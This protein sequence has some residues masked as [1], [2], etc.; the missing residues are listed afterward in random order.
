MPR[1]DLAALQRR[2]AQQQ[3]KD[4]TPVPAEPPS[5]ST[6]TVLASKKPARQAAVPIPTRPPRQPTPP[7]PPPAA[8][9]E[10]A[11]RAE[12]ADVQSERPPDARVQT[13]RPAFP[14]HAP[15]DEA[16]RE[17]NRRMEEAWHRA[18]EA[19]HRAR[20]QSREAQELRRARSDALLLELRARWPALFTMPVPLAIGIDGEIR[21][22]L[23]QEAAAAGTAAPS[24]SVLKGTMAWWTTERLPRGTCN[25]DAPRRPG[26]AAGRRDH[27]PRSGARTRAAGGT[28]GRAGFLTRNGDRRRA[29]LAPLSTSFPSLTLCAARSSLFTMAEKLRFDVYP[30][31]ELLELIDRWRGQQPGVPSRAEAARRLL[32]DALEAKVKRQPARQQKAAGE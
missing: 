10:E 16:T 1:I 23:R 30:T 19:A 11:Q 7:P 6:R 18:R 13:A 26:W 17:H 28:S 4:S 8:R 2:L 29:G 21:D 12:A 20:E 3:S 31:P 15:A 32:T 5:W 27:R 14:P 9:A 22:T 24:W 25:R